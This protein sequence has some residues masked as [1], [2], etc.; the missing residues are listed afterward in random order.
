MPCSSSVGA[1]TTSVDRAQ[2]SASSS[3]GPPFSTTSQRRLC[4]CPSSMSQR[5]RLQ[6]LIPPCVS[7]QPCL[8][9]APILGRPPSAMVKPC[10]TGASDSP[11]TTSSGE[12]EWLFRGI[13]FTTQ[14]GS[15]SVQ[16]CVWQRC[17]VHPRPLPRPQDLC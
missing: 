1:F 7:S 16:P 5:D 14:A 6:L 15:I 13:P 4:I 8:L 17:R 12:E 11:Y 9:P 2:P 10:H 3:V